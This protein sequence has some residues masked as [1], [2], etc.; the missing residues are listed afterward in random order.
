MRTPPPPSLLGHAPLARP[1]HPEY[2]APATILASTHCGLPLAWDPTRRRPRQRVTTRRFLLCVMTTRTRCV[3][4]PTNEIRHDEITARLRRHTKTIRMSCFVLPLGKTPYPSGPTRGGYFDTRGIRRTCLRGHHSI[5]PFALFP[6]LSDPS[7]SS[8]SP[9]HSPLVACLTHFHTATAH[10]SRVPNLTQN[11][12]P[13]P[14]A[15][16]PPSARS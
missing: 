4:T 3:L 2:D 15:V 14:Q 7:Y 6:T 13:P 12:A 9:P 1:P 10:D 16:V 11:P 5:V 8:S